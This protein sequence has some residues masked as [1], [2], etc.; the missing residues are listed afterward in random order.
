MTLRIAKFIADAGV[1]SRRAAEE[2]IARGRVAVNGKPVDTPVVFVNPSADVVTIDG[3]RVAPRTE[4][5]LYA[6]H[7]PINTM[8]TARDPSGRKT[9]YD[10]LPPEYRGLKYVGRLDYKTTGLLL[11]TNDGELARKLTH[12]SSHIPRT[13]IAT[14]NGDDMSGLD[15]ARAGI[16]IDGVKYRPMQIDVVG[17]RTLRVTVTEGKK[18][19]VRIVLRACRAPV[20]HLRRVSFGPVRLGNLAPGEIRPVNQKTID[21]LLKS[22]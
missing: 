15:A 9:V 6:F 21:E 22:L 13:Y 2:M 20:R 5:T 11:M 7:K 16:T 4:S 18:N 14:V 8:T 17:P 12:P 3:V 19:E 10:C 1:A